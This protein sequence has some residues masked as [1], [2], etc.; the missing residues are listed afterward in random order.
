MTL[1][2]AFF[3]T[4]SSN[5]ESTGNKNKAPVVVSVL[6][7]IKYKNFRVVVLRL[8]L[9]TGFK[10]AV[11]HAAA[12]LYGINHDFFVLQR[13]KTNYQDKNNFAALLNSVCFMFK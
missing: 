8:C 1:I 10:E 9:S 13:E 7:S 2:T 3:T 4:L 6:S 11:Q 5:G 12:G